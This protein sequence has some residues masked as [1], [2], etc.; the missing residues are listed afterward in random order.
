MLPIVRLGHVGLHVSALEPSVAFYGQLG[1]EVVA[2]ADTER[3]I[4]L[5]HHGGVELTL[6]LT[7]RPSGPGLTFG[8]VV[9]L[10][11][12]QRAVLD[13]AGIP[14]TVQ[15]DQNGHTI[16]VLT[17][18]DGVTVEL[19]ESNYHVGDRTEPVQSLDALSTR[20]GLST[21]PNRRVAGRR[22]GVEVCL[23]QSETT[24]SIQATVDD[25]LPF[26]LR[27]LLIHSQPS[28]NICTT[29]AL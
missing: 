18:P 16:L 26:R 10:V 25:V 27:V 12:Q 11:E 4:V 5:R 1:F 13:R 6:T 22:D 7:D 29:V 20:L 23:W 15:H 14:Y 17:D 21:Q 8:L 3:C 9:R 28:I 19:G 2:G 24:L